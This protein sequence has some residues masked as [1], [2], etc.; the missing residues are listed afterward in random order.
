MG[1]FFQAKLNVHP[2]HD[3]YEQEADAMADRV[4]SV[5]QGE[6]FTPAIQKQSE[7]EGLQTKPLVDEI[8]RIGSTD[9]TSTQHKPAFDS[10]SEMDQQ[11][12]SGGDVQGKS[13]GMD[14]QMQE[15]S[16]EE[17][18][19]KGDPV[20]P[21]KDFEQN[22][23][24]SKGGGQALPTSTQSRM[25]Q[26]FGANFQ[27]VR[28]HTGT[29][30]VQMS[31]SI[32]AQAF[33]HGKDIY[34]NEGKYQ[35]GTSE[36]DHLIA[37]ELT[38]TVQQSGVQRKANNGGFEDIQA[39]FI[40]DLINDLVSLAG[41]VG[42]N[43]PEI[44]DNIPGYTLFSYITEY[45]IIRGRSVERNGRNLIRGLMGLI[46][47]GN[48]L[49]N[50]LDE[51]GI[52]DRAF[53]WVESQLST[54]D[55]SMGRIERTFERAWDEMG[56]S[57]GISGNLR[58]LRNNFQPLLNDIETFADNAVDQL[59]EFV[60][61]ALVRPLVEFLE[62]NS[63]A[64]KLATKVIGKK[65]PLDDEVNAPTVEILEDFLVLIGKQT[66]VD[67]M[68][69]KG[70]LQETADWIDTQLSTFFSLLG[71]FN[72]IVSRVWDAFSLETL[73]DIPGVFQGIWDDFTELL[74]DFLDFALEVAVKVLELIKNA[75]LSFLA[76][77]ADDIPG[78]HLL[79]VIIEKNPFTDE[80]VPRTTENLIRGFMSLV[81][82]GDAKFREL[83]ES[84][85]IPRAAQRIDALIA[86]LGI[87]WEFIVGLFTGIWESLSIDDLIDPIGAFQRI[88]DQYGEPIGRL[89]SFV[90]EVVKILMELILEIMGIPP[91]MIGNII[92]NTMSAFEDI[93]ND[94]VGFLLNLMNAIKEGFLQFLN[95]I[96]THLL[97]GL[98]T[99][100]FGTLADAGIQIPSDLSLQS[101]LG[102]AMDVL[103]ITVDNVLDRLG[104]RI[105][106]ERVEQ[107]RGVLD[108]LTGI[109]AFVRDVIERGPIAIWEYVQQQLSNLWDIIKD[110]IM[111]FIQEKVIQ[112]AI[113]WLLSFL[114]VTGIMPIIRGV[115]TVFNAIQSFIEKLREILEIVNSF[116]AG[117]AEIARGNIK[118]AADFLE[119]ALADG[120]PVAISFLAKQLGLGDISEKIAEMIEA[121]RAKIN[122][123]IDWL[124][125]QALRA[126]TAFLNALG[127]GGDNENA[128]GEQDE[129][130]VNEVPEGVDSENDIV[131]E[132]SFDTEEHEIRAHQN[133][134]GDI[135]ITMASAG[136]GD[137]LQRVHQIKDRYK[138]RVDPERKS[139]F[140]DEMAD[141]AALALRYRNEINLLHPRERLAA[142]RPKLREL[143]AELENIALEYDFA[144]A[145]GL[146]H[147]FSIGD[148]IIDTNRNERM[149]VTDA[150]VRMGTTFGVKARPVNGT[151][152]RQ[153]SF[154]NFDQSWEAVNL[155]A[156]PAPVP[157][158]SG[159]GQ[160]ITISVHPM[161]GGQPASGDYPM[162][163]QN[164]AAGQYYAERGHLIAQ[165]FG[166]KNNNNNIAAMT[167]TANDR[168]QSLETRVRNDVINGAA[169]EYRVTI[170]P[171]NRQPSGPMAG[172]FL[173]PANI[174]I[175]AQR[176]WPTN[177]N[178]SNIQ[179]TTTIPN[180]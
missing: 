61:D 48:L 59:I 92:A 18:Q 38:H 172:K 171:T 30:A 115:Q 33:T 43:I 160:T 21:P 177:Q 133:E 157:P 75:L 121:A 71:R 155:A 6:G 45:D 132:T 79:T 134:A 13:A 147:Q 153:Y 123:G 164:G 170:S 148:H 150:S 108:T 68:K 103:G 137:Y 31:Q 12:G 158:G 32:G 10:P 62:A 51:Y 126:G 57:E 42:I 5:P 145:S 36:G 99:W 138:D 178:P 122:E 8:T 72:A 90:V 159:Y 107:I 63:E 58:I 100:L 140:E 111:G 17:L 102:M 109:W 114:D 27:D 95:N 11:T 179:A 34:F 165:M 167:A 85:A 113:T 4:V 131:V 127:L 118:S 55:I 84:G 14:L 176:V 141:V 60:K 91:D 146:P 130:A 142:W 65:F 97:N 26:G 41:R 15:E 49:Y 50:K 67:E 110:G 104:E 82:G 89:F 3:A 44:V 151:A 139:D 180:T 163:K 156:K 28:V 129:E 76:S 80:A 23:Q 166:G 70:T 9:T 73:E 106:Q 83:K 143:D 154:E 78:F 112:Q 7:E 47:G 19:A 101:L 116:V 69:E 88:A 93:K 124:I 1:S 54:L 152:E 169:Y 46:P 2:A 149:V 98:Q 74:Q 168:M 37:H 22:L 24:G 25:E 173:P 29:N 136:W 66:E 64:Y 135:I 120:I 119:N 39:S 87:S 144:V 128:E 162:W 96:G 81:P 40:R 20:N 77:F 174:I 161:P 53:E 56:I 125:D 86:Q 175:S 16:E 35:P 105:G 52:I 117:I 94:P